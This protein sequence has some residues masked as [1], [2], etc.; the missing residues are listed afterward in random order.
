MFGMFSSKADR[1]FID[2]GNVNCPVRGADVEVDL[3]LGCPRLVEI[4]EHAPAPYVR[5]EPVRR[6]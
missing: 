2:H 6:L 1:L 3:C 5:C 4:D